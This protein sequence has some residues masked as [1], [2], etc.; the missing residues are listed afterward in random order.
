LYHPGNS[1]GNTGINTPNILGLS[2]IWSVPWYQNAGG[3]KGLALGGWKCSDI[4]T[5]QSGFSLNPGLSI[6]TKG[7]ATKPD[8]VSSNV[9]GPKT[10]AQW[11]NTGAFA[12]PPA[13]FFGNAAPGSIPGP[14]LVN[15]DMAFYK[16]FRIT[17]RQ[18]VEIR[19]EL[20]NIFNHTNFNAVGTS[21][22]SGTYGHLVG[23]ADPRIVEFVLRYQF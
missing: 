3:W 12:A 5:I 1:Y 18:K 2:A 22:G 20:F 15:F 10:V 9:Q 21:L 4:T 19:G 7:L 8:R 16:D 23:A 13:G 17:E 6:G 11:F 14:G